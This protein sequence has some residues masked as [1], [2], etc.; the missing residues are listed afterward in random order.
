MSS[1]LTDHDVAPGP[2]KRCQI[3]GS[4]NI[5]LVIDLGH[6]P[7]CDTLVTREGLDQPEKTYPLRLYHCPESGLA[8]LD[9]AVAGEELYAPSYPYMGGISWPLKVHHKGLADEIMR[10]VGPRD[11]K[12]LVVDIGSN[13]GTLL[14]QFQQHHPVRVLGVEPTDVALYAIRENGVQTLQAF[15]TERV[16]KDI[17]AIEGKAAVITTTSVFAHMA[18]LGEVM[19]G[20]CALLAHDGMFVIETHYLLDVLL[21][22][23]FDTIYHEHLRTYS[24]KSLCALFPQ[25]GL[26]VFAAERTERYGGDLRAFVGWKGARPVEAGVGELLALE[27]KHKLHDSAT[28]ALFRDRI[29]LQ[30]DLLMEFLYQARGEGKRVAGVSCPG[31]CSTLLNFYGIGPDLIEYLGE[32]PTSLKLGHYLPGRHIPIVDNRRIAKE[33]PDVLVLMAWHYADKIVPRLRSE[34]IRSQLVM[35]LPEFGIVDERN[36][37]KAAA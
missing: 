20:I 30:R 28:W 25:Y 9:Y 5:N 8:Q 11:K 2:L 10:R 16:A 22:N 24:L 23:Q 26:E 15:F 33:Q 17:A 6:Q 31:R 29:L 4:K 7:L 19:R 3:T 32:L 18:T 37:L 1:V 14:S 12:P 34:G 13:D 35:P 21:K 36:P 27:E